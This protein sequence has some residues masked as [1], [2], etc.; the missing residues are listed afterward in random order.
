VASPESNAPRTYD[1]DFYGFVRNAARS[2]AEEIVPLLLELTGARSVVDVGCGLG[3]WLAVFSEHG[4]ADV[5]GLDGP[6]VDISA[7]EI[8]PARFRVSDLERPERLDRRFDLALCLETA[9]HISS[10][11]AESLIDFLVS[12][13]PVVCFSAAI[14][15]QSGVGHVNEQWATYW[16]RHFAKRRY[17]VVDAIRP[18]VWSSERVAMWYAQ[19]SLLFVEEAVIERSPALARAHDATHLEQLN[20]VH[21][22]LFLYHALG[23]TDRV[24]SVPLDAAT[25]GAV[26]HPPVQTGDISLRELLRRVARAAGRALRSRRSRRSRARGR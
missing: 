26:R 19:N 11:R 17:A 15:M 6:E 23:A 9:E 21:P 1:D 20:V 25:D 18:A 10:D 7:L 4:V 16:V 12:L 3:T 14:P 2:S 5:V 8:P 22:S 13:A 24:A